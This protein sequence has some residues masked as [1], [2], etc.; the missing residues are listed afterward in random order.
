MEVN[1]IENEGTATVKIEGRIDTSTAPALERKLGK[2]VKKI[3]NVCLDFE[4]VEYITS[5]GLR[6]VLATSKQVSEKGKLTI[7][8]SSPVVK[9][10]FDMTG[11][12]SVV[13][14]D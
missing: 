12:S 14:I 5:A 11:F 7:V 8:N 2:I 4:K 10:I 3:N 6:V 1:I 13:D 9:E